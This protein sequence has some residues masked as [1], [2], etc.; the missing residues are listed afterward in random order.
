MARVIRGYAPKPLFNLRH[1]K[2][3]TVKVNPGTLGEIT[4]RM[5]AEGDTLKANIHTA[6]KDCNSKNAL[7]N[8]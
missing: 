3:L 1:S 4:I 7:D 8:P 6:N 5:V 2:E